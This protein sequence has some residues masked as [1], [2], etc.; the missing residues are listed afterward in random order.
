MVA[1][2]PNTGPQSSII[3]IIE[4]VSARGSPKDCVVADAVAFEPVSTPVFPANREINR[5]F[6]RTRPLCMILKVDTRAKSK[7]FSQIPYAIEQGIILAEQGILAQEQGILPGQNQNHHRMRFSVRT[8]GL[9]PGSAN[10]KHQIAP[11]PWRTSS[12]LRSGL[13]F[14]YTQRPFRTSKLGVDQH[15]KNLEAVIVASDIRYLG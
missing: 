10:R 2:A 3:T 14:R 8:T 7:A 5:E 11:R 9:A 13:G 6:C 15:L 1:T 4:P 12:P